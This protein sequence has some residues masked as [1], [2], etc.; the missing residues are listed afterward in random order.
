MNI[1]FVSQPS[2]WSLFFRKGITAEEA[3][4]ITEDPLLFEPVA[5]TLESAIVIY[6]LSKVICST[7]TTVLDKK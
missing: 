1:L 4:T 7:T 6:K 3:K 5:A 2:Y